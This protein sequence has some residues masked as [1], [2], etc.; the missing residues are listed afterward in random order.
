M[1]NP[2]TCFSSNRASVVLATIEQVR[3]VPTMG[4]PSLHVHN[5]QHWMEVQ[6]LSHQKS[7]ATSTC[8]GFWLKEEKAPFLPY[9]GEEM[10]WAFV[11]LALIGPF[12]I[13]KIPKASEEGVIPSP[14]SW[15]WPH[16]PLRLSHIDNGNSG[17]NWR[18]RNLKSLK[19]LQI[20]EM[21]SHRASYM[22]GKPVG[23]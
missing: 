15:S 14:S 20:K 17:H 6:V 11:S 1:P 7:D 2:H 4:S 21:T 10:S 19:G 12:W 18:V 8:F 22:G 3:M 9:R 16:H 5:T 13:S 23:I